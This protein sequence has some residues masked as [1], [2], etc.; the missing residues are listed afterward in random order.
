[1]EQ[2]PLQIANDSLQNYFENTIIPQLY[3]D[4]ELVLRKFTPPAMKQFSLSNADI[5]KNMVDVVDN[6]RY[7][8]IIENIEKILAIEL[9][10]AAQAMEFRR[11][12]KSSA[13]LESFLSDYRQVVSFVEEDTLMYVGINKTIE[14]LEKGK[15][16]L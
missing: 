14:F 4:A 6:I 9:L 8:T 15:Y 3:V 12:A 16:Y 7:P 11:P 2:E 5:G 1:M 10:N 13:Y